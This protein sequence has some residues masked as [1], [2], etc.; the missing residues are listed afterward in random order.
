MR[1]RQIVTAML[2]AA[3]LL[4]GAAR[5]TYPGDAGRLAFGIRGADGNVDV[6]SVRPDGNGLDRL[7]TA[8]GPDI[9]PAY[10]ADGKR[11][12]FCSNRG[13][14][15]QV[16]TMRSDGSDQREVTH[17]GVGIFPDWAPSGRR[18]AFAGKRAASDP[19][20]DIFSV[21]RDG[22]DLVQLTTDPGDDLYPAWSPNGR[23]IAFLSN[24]TGIGQVWV[25]NA[26]GSGQVQLTFDAVHKD[27]LPDWSPDGTKIAYQTG[28][29]G[30]GRIWMMNADGSGQRQLTFGP[31]DDFGTAWSPDGAKIA[32]VRD[33]SA[34]DRPVM[35][36]N[37]DGSDQ[38]RLLPIASLQF[39]PAWQPRGG[40]DH[41]DE[42]DR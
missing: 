15:F 14:G 35:V 8:P 21:R 7:T 39:V 38:H 28:T 5:A 31:D 41:D 6:Y 10:S 23:K 34:T 27:Q 12:A 36:M 22:S 37:A 4:A 25:M 20:F 42:R 26:D 2:L 30:N 13:D 24:R 18:I 19:T 29:I 9:C 1:K 3:G 33:I 32:F 11:I 16:W 40:G 17:V